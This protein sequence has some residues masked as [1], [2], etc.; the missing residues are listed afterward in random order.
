LIHGKPKLKFMASENPFTKWQRPEAGTQQPVNPS[1]PMDLRWRASGRSL[2]REAL[3][4][5]QLEA[6][7]DAVLFRW[8]VSLVAIVAI[9]VAIVFFTNARN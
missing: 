6:Q 3:N 4:E 1:K 2:R 9:V 8:I 7:R 5:S